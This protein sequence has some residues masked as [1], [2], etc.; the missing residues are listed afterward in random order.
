LAEK[1]FKM[2][3]K[4]RISRREFFKKA[5]AAA[6]AATIGSIPLINACKGS[7]APSQKVSVNVQFYNHTLGP[8]VE[9]TYEGISGNSF[10]IKISDLGMTDVTSTR[11]AVRK[12]GNRETMDSL[13]KF[14]LTGEVSLKYPENNESWEAYLM[15]SGNGAPYGIIDNMGE[16][17]G[18]LFYGRHTVW[19]RED[20]NN[21][22]GPEEPL[23]EAVRQL[24]EALNH[25][26]KKYGSFIKQDTQGILNI[27]YC[28]NPHYW[29]QDYCYIVPADWSTSEDK[30]KGF[31]SVIFR[32]V[33]QTGF[34]QDPH[35]IIC[36]QSTGNLN[37]VGRDLID[38]IYVRDGNY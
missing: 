36:D 23:L 21:A 6:G 28:D 26:W 34:P 9:K 15:N 2:I 19:C 1:E 3:C 24:G 16:G 37:A 4:S 8:Q 14:S 29:R 11:I 30:L 33:T 38:Y 22:T 12:A 10:T 32:V 7:T 17:W 13:I 5:G 27:G 35:Y 20:I 31:I 25:P 18:K